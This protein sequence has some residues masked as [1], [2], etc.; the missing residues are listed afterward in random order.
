MHVHIH[1]HEHVHT[2]AHSHRPYSPAQTP[3]HTRTHHLD[4]HVEKDDRVVRVALFFPR[5]LI[6][7]PFS[8]PCH[9]SQAPTRSPAM[10]IPTMLRSPAHLPSAGSRRVLTRHFLFFIGVASESLASSLNP[11][12][13]MKGG[14]CLKRAGEDDCRHVPQTVSPH[15]LLT[16]GGVRVKA[17]APICACVVPPT[18]GDETCAACECRTGCDMPPMM[19]AE[20][21]AACMYVH[22][23]L[24]LSRTHHVHRHR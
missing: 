21:C 3:A 17:R 19:A 12:T 4:I 1:N 14:A 24:C 5:C 9:A 7:H 23:C 22:R 13:S 20:T 8:L 2:R 10:T 16:L 15:L 18:M 6:R 11:A